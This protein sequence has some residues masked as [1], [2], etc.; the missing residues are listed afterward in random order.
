MTLIQ[1]FANITHTDMWKTVDLLNV[2]PD[3][4]SSP[5]AYPLHGSLNNI[6]RLYVEI[7]TDDILRD[8][9]ACYAKGVETAGGV[10]KLVEIQVS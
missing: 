6:P 4:L 7:C 2:P 10:V 9:G 3:E 5:G 8:D 1:I